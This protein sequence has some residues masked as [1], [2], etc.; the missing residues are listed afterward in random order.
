MNYTEEDVHDYIV[1]TLVI[2]KSRKQDY[3]DVRNYLLA[4][5]YYNFK[6]TEEELQFIYKIDRSTINVSKKNPYHLLK[7]NDYDFLKH[8]EEVRLKFPY[9]FPEP[10]TKSKLK[11]RKKTTISLN[12]MVYG[13]VKIFAEK[14]DMYLHTAIRLLIKR[15]LEWVE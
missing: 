10:S 8:T 3:L 9:V 6:H 1:N 13:Q 14:N 4:I 15:G 5:L 7:L 11:H 12:T 2:K